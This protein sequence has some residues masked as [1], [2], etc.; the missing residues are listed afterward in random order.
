MTRFRTAVG[1]I[2]AAAVVATATVG[3][4]AVTGGSSARTG[5]I[6]VTWS[7]GQCET[8]LFCVSLTGQLDLD[9][10][11]VYVDCHASCD[12]NALAFNAAT[13]HI[14]RLDILTE[15]QDGVKIR[16]AAHDLTIDG[17]TVTADGHYPATHQDCMQALTGT[18]ILFQHVVFSCWSATNAQ[19]YIDGLSDPAKPV[20]VVCDQ[21]EFHPNSFHDVTIGLSDRSGVT[22]SLVCPGA[23]QALQFDV[24]P[25]AVNPVDVGNAKPW[26][27]DPRCPPQGSLPPPTTS[28]AAT[29]TVQATT[30]APTTSSVATTTAPLP[31]TAAELIANGFV[32]LRSQATLYATWA[33]A[34]PG[35]AL[36]LDLYLA[37]GGIPPVLVTATGRTL[38]L[39]AEAGLLG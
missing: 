9:T 6:D 28:T 18:N 39:F 29:T 25:D 20:N 16:G 36:K 4:V 8:T 12:T 19:W 33:K 26:P 35:E 38:V 2:V 30:T 14:K 13:G 34:N 11:R 21:C 3:V 24:H 32:I 15:G 22:N 1:G 23:S 31:V 10:V 27:S 5:S 37:N 17:G 7:K